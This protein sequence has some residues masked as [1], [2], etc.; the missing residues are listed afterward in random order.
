M[1]AI[2]NT[3]AIWCLRC[4]EKDAATQPDLRQGWQGRFRTIWSASTSP[5]WHRRF[6]R[7]WS[8]SRS[9]TRYGRIREAEENHGRPRF[10]KNRRL[11]G[12]DDDLRWPQGH[13]Q[14]NVC[15]E[16]HGDDPCCNLQ[17]IKGT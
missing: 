15:R 16:A 9:A 13:H 11:R 14:G 12:A 5:I 3:S 7:F 17:K 10:R 1:P 6:R 4:R 8:N 2:I